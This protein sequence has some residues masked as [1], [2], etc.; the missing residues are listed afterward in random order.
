[1]PGEERLVR[2]AETFEGFQLAGAIDAAFPVVSDVEG[3]DT[4]GVAGDEEGV[5][6]LI[7][8]REGEDAVQVL[9]E[10]GAFVAVEREDDL[11]VAS[12]L[13]VVASGIPRTDVAVVV[14]LAVHGQNLFPVRGVERL[15]AA[16]RVDD[17]EPFVAKYGTLATI[18][19]AP[20]RS[21]VAYLLGH[22]QCF[23]A[24]FRRLFLDIENGCNSTHD[25]CL[26]RVGDIGRCRRRLS[27]RRRCSA[28]R[29][30]LPWRRRPPRTHSRGIPVA[31]DGGSP[32]PA[33][34]GRRG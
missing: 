12:R 7:V 4:D 8:E 1:M 29:G 15:P 28:R 31:W 2:V 13:E 6:L 3:D 19:A 22:G 25:V 27:V 30:W 17:G 14:N 23:P 9:Q 34:R 10:G 11:A 20:V 5:L 18:D 24:Q 33:G 16:L 26:F 32:W 21:A